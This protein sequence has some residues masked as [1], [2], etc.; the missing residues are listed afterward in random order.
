MPRDQRVAGST[1]YTKVGGRVPA[2]AVYALNSDNTESLVNYASRGDYLVVEQVAPGYV[3]RRGGLKSTLYNDAFKV[4][5]L[6]AQSPKPR[7]K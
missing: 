3:L 7:Q 6:D 2:P 1:P 4:Q 5:G